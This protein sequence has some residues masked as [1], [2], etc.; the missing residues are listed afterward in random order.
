MRP[1]SPTRSQLEPT[2]TDELASRAS[3][4]KYQFACS[5]ISVAAVGPGKRTA[6]QFELHYRDT[7]GARRPWAPGRGHFGRN[8]AGDSGQDSSSA[9]TRSGAVVSHRRRRPPS[10]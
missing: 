2:C 9:A 1:T 6:A 4:P 5:E 8:Q 7:S 3:D 10:R